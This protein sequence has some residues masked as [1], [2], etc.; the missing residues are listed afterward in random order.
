MLH[1]VLE[2]LYA[3]LPFLTFLQGYIIGRC[4]GL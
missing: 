1:D 3:A 2:V 4:H